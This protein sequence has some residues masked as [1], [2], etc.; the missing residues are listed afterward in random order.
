MNN[1]VHIVKRI[2]TRNLWNIK[3][4]RFFEKFHRIS[5]YV[6]RYLRRMDDNERAILHKAQIR[7]HYRLSEESA[8]VEALFGSSD[9]TEAYF[10]IDVAIS[11]LKGALAEFEYSLEKIGF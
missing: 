4:N 3:R 2:Y 1:E 11:N 7:F 10:A 5:E 9:P 6:E 8:K